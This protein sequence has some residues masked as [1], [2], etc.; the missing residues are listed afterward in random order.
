M[1]S[2]DELPA[3][4]LLNV[5]VPGCATTDIAG[6]EV[7]SLGR[8]IYRDKLQLQ[9]EDGARKRYTLYG[10]DPSHHDEPGTDIAAI[11]RSC[12]AVTPIRFRLVD[13]RVSE[14]VRHWP[15]ATF[16]A[17]GADL[18]PAPGVRT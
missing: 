8:R 14:Q 16:A 9:G 2:E 6:V 15:F 11:G 13:E 10:D 12:I 17:D 18:P 7:G 5:N 1:T 4:L 3:G